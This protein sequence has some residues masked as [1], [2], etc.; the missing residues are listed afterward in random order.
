MQS[1]RPTHPT[2]AE[3]PSLRLPPPDRYTP[4]A[5]QHVL[6]CLEVVEIDIEL[7]G[8]G[9]VITSIDDGVLERVSDGRV[10]GSSREAG[11][12]RARV[13]RAQLRAWLARVAKVRDRRRPRP[14]R[15]R[16][17]R[18]PVRAAR[19]AG[20]ASASTGPPSDDDPPPPRPTDPG[21]SREGSAVQPATAT[22]ARCARG[23]HPP[24]GAVR[25]EMERDDPLEDQ[26][27]PAACPACGTVGHWHRPGP[28]LHADCV[29]ALGRSLLFRL[30]R[31]AR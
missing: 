28:V 30:R 1:T 21:G 11:L 23:A 29:A 24:M 18:S 22:M 19:R 25:P 4:E 13:E 9:R 7:A 27:G 20:S 14:A 12:R 8:V 17:P 31:S 5:W 26:R 10:S 15:Q 2:Q 6:D 3:Q 16:A